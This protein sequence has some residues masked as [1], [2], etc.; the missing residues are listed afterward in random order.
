MKPLLVAVVLVLLVAAAIVGF[1][2]WNQLHR[3]STITPKFSPPAEIQS[4]KF[5]PLHLQEIRLP[6][7]Y[8]FHYVGTWKYPGRG[9]VRIVFHP[10]KNDPAQWPASLAQAEGRADQ[11][12]AR[13]R[14]IF[15]AGTKELT[16]LFKR[17]Q[18]ETTKI[19]KIYPD[20]KLS[21]LKLISE[22]DDELVYAPCKWFPSIDLFISISRDYRVTSAHFDG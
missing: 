4:A 13:E 17:Y 1:T 6:D 2:R 19:E 14:T 11:L 3:A 21:T 7:F 10:P 9:A 5:G 15:L 22:G 18:I 20:L 16:P 8:A 12:A